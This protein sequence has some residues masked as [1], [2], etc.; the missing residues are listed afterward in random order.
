MKNLKQA[1]H[2]FL[3]E[4]SLETLHRESQNWTSE[5]K[6]WKI[7]L[8]FFQKLLDNNSQKFDSI[9]DKKRMSHFQNLIIYYI[10]EVLDQFKQKI[11]RHEKYLAEEL[12]NKE[13]LDESEYRKRHAEIAS[14]VGSFRIEFIMYKRE[15]FD[16]IEKVM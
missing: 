13:H 4:E 8:K 14:H 5:L 12:T 7:E 6:L 1:N 9:E 2:D 16:F 11:R 10:G 3:L 15:F